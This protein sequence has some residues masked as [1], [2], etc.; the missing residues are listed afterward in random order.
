GFDSAKRTLGFGLNALRCGGVVLGC[1]LLGMCSFQ[2]LKPDI[3]FGY[4]GAG[5][6]FCSVCLFDASPKF[7][8]RR[9]RLHKLCFKMLIQSFIRHGDPSYLRVVV[10]WIYLAG[11]TSSISRGVAFSKASPTLASSF[12]VMP[13]V[14][15]RSPPNCSKS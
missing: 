9:V 13:S 14:T 4:C 11:L 2:L 6:R 7:C 3:R 12:Q 15:V 5:G 8:V 1:L 10:C